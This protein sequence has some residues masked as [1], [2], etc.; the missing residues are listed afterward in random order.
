[1]HRRVQGDRFPALAPLLPRP[2]VPTSTAMAAALCNRLDLDG[3]VTAYTVET[4][5]LTSEA[6][7]LADIV[8]ALGRA[9]QSP[10]SSSQVY[11]QLAAKT[12][13][14]CMVL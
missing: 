2:T 6:H 3:M 12:F 4:V 5:Y 10:P 8:G 9:P 11:R 14:L 7:N 1:M 13:F